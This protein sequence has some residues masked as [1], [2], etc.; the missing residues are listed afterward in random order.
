V[1][2]MQLTLVECS[3]PMMGNAAGAAAVEHLMQQLHQACVHNTEGLSERQLIA[4]WSKATH[5]RAAAARIALDQV[6]SINIYQCTCAYSYVFR[7][8]HLTASMHTYSYLH[9]RGSAVAYC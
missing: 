6:C 2:Q 4:E 5:E 8:M 1:L 9:C 7:C 3:K